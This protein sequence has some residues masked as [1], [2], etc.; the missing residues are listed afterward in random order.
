[1]LPSLPEETQQELAELA[2]RYGQPLIRIVDLGTTN[3]FDPLNKTDR[4]GEVCMVVRRLNGHLLTMKKTFYPTGAYRL[5]TGGIHHGEH[6]FDALLRE[7]Q[8]ETGLEVAVRRFL[9]IAAYRASNT[10]EQPIF[11]TFAFLLDE[12]GGTLTTSDE[13]EQVEDFREI[14]P[15]ALQERAAWFEHIPS[16]PSTH[17]SG[18]W[19][20]WGHFRAVIHRLVWE[21]LSTTE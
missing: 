6:I 4:Y 8:E 7:V 12:L 20:D 21:A 19:K 3:Q 15:G 9:A 1:M 13:D 14:A 16:T 18:D 5:L 17:I 10:S 11:Y 2:T